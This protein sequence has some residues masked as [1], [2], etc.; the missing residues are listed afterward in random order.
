MPLELVDEVLA[1]PTP[2]V[3]E[4]ALASPE[5]V[6]PELVFA[7]PPAP[8]VRVT[9]AHATMLDP[10]NTTLAPIR[11]GR[12]MRREYEGTP[13]FATSLQGRGEIARRT[14]VP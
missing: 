14:A 11:K 9:C 3:P 6:E 1:P 5:P 12:P 13:R 7:D 8:M 4:D 2:P 10:R